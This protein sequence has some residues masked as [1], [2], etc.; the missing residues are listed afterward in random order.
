MG[1]LWLRLDVSTSEPLSQFPHIRRGCRNEEH[2][3]GD[4]GFSVSTIPNTKFSTELTLQS[5]K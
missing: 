3:I 5:A 2:G 4:A 1:I